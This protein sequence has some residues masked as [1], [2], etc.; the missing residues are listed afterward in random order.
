MRDIVVT[1]E[2]FCL[3]AARHY[4]DIGASDQEF[5]EDLRRF[6]LVKRLFNMYLKSGDIKDRLIINHLIVI[7]NVFDQAAVPLLFHELTGFESQLVPFLVVLNRLPE[8]IGD[9]YTSSFALDNK[10]VECLRMSLAN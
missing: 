2:N 10:V 4:E 6:A 1:A 3:V 7:F 5:E 8:K 9:V